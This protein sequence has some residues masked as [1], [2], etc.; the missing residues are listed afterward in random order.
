MN[1]HWI[2]A[3]GR[4]LISALL[5]ANGRTVKFQNDFAAVPE[6]E[7]NPEAIIVKLNTTSGLASK[8]FVRGHHDEAN[9]SFQQTNEARFLLH[10]CGI[11]RERQLKPKG[12][13]VT[14]TFVVQL[15]PFFIT[16]LDRAYKV[17][18]FYLEA[19]HTITSNLEVSTISPSPI[20][21]ETSLPQCKYNLRMERPDG[22]AVRYA[23]IG[24]RVWHVWEC[25]AGD[26]YGMLV[27]SCS[28]RDGKGNQ[29]EIIDEKGCALDDFIMDTPKYNDSLS[30]AE[31]ETLVFKFADVL[32]VQFHCQ[33][34][35]CVKA[36]NGCEG[37]TPPV[38]ENQTRQLELVHVKPEPIAEG[39]EGENVTESSAL[40][41]E[42]EL[43]T[44]A[45]ASLSEEG[46]TTE[47]AAEQKESPAEQLSQDSVMPVNSSNSEPGGPEQADGSGMDSEGSGQPASN[48]SASEVTDTRSRRNVYSEP[49]FTDTPYFEMPSDLE[50]D[51]SQEILVLDV[52]DTGSSLNDDEKP[53][54]RMPIR[55]AQEQLPESNRRVCL[56]SGAL[57]AVVSG[58]VFVVILLSL[59][60]FVMLI[61]RHQARVNMMGAYSTCRAYKF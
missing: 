59:A 31:Q 46:E 36:N 41:A 4:L 24:D 51:V 10:D 61:K 40:A 48:S 57:A 60:V 8:I 33:I 19:D 43:T 32:A 53:D 55:E 26:S 47:A 3:A 13:A 21:Q 54:I 25:D 45:N 35:L 30:S 27:H 44:S 22:E 29:I 11:V 20:D 39:A 42:G 1:Y 38:C 16:K 14:S 52:G 28:V 34:K 2:S 6:V 5:V 15:H 7:C 18:C 12:V 56:T 17:R 9:C 58:F 23:R 37:I 50:A 49:W